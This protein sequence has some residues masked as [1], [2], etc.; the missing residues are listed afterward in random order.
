M[1]CR[2]RE[3]SREPSRDVSD[4]AGAALEQRPDK[5]EASCTAMWEKNIPSRE[6]S[7]GKGPTQEVLSRYVQQT[8]GDLHGWNTG[9]HGGHMM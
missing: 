6:H 5:K 3:Q 1:L 7:P 2:A 4:G 8:Q 9:Q